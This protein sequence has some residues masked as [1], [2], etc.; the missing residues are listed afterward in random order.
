MG[1]AG[2]EL[3]AQVADAW[4]EGLGE[5]EKE[6]DAEARQLRQD[7]QESHALKER[8]AAFL[9]A[10]KRAQANGEA[11]SPTPLTYDPRVLMMRALFLICRK[12]SPESS[13]P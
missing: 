7:G 11:P 1:V 4:R 10:A 13:S 3:A 8:E 5:R 6:L 2:I 12:P 9:R